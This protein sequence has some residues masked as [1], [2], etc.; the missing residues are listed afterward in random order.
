MSIHPSR[1]NGTLIWQRSG[2]RE[3]ESPRA[4]HSFLFSFAIHLKSLRN[5]TVNSSTQPVSIASEPTF[6]PESASQQGHAKFHSAGTTEVS[7]CLRGC[8]TGVFGA[9][10]MRCPFCYFPAC[11]IRL[12]EIN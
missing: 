4:C 10:R 12:L 6:A 1:L 2:G 8:G 3:F 7:N 11:C 9:A 5:V